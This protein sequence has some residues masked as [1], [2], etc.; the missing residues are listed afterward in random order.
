VKNNLDKDD[1]RSLKETEGSGLKHVIFPKQSQFGYACYQF[2][3]ERVTQLCFGRCT[4]NLIAG[5]STKSRPKEQ[6]NDSLFFNDVKLMY[7]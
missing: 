1:R 6:S 2:A 5:L 4:L 3:A 7:I